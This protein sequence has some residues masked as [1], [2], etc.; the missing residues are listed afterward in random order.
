MES[1]K[2]NNEY[3]LCAFMFPDN[4][5][6]PIFTV[7]GNYNKDSN[8]WETYLKLFHNNAYK[9]YETMQIKQWKDVS[10]MKE[11]FK[12]LYKA[13]ANKIAQIPNDTKYEAENT[14]LF[15]LFNKNKIKLGIK[16][17]SVPVNMV[18]KDG[19]LIITLLAVFEEFEF[20]KEDVFGYGYI[21]VTNDPTGKIAGS[22]VSLGYYNY[23]SILKD[24]KVLSMNPIALECN[25]KDFELKH[26]RACRRV[27]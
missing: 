7:N 19:K 10:E 17:P 16:V 6:K 20:N 8:Q 15:S 5:N 25:K 23:R 12:C 1:N 27:M 14:I 26:L 11:A 24:C 18:E 9:D 21:D 2:E 22:T 3:K 4:H 13:V